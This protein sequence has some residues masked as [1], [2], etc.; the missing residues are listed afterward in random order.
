MTHFQPSRPLYIDL[1]ASKTGF[2]VMVYHLEGDTSELV[3]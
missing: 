1:D 3:K 2:G